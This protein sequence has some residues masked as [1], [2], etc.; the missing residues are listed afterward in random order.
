[1]ATNKIMKQ[2]RFVCFFVLRV[3]IRFSSFFIFLCGGRTPSIAISPSIAHIFWF[4]LVG[5]SLKRSCQQFCFLYC[6][7]LSTYSLC[8]LVWTG[9]LEFS[10]FFSCQIMAAWGI[11]LQTV[12]SAVF[13][14]SFLMF[15]IF[16]VLALILVITLSCLH[17]IAVPPCTH[18][19][20]GHFSPFLSGLH[21]VSSI[22]PPTPEL[23]ILL[24]CTV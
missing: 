7:Q 3:V 12:K 17:P 22:P 21:Q 8:C 24:L 23:F 18:A 10:L 19:L 1:M 9:Y 20:L 11:I 15:I 6:W 16:V 5:F 13:A 14:F 4:F 2:F